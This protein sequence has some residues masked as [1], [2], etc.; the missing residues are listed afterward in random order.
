LT[1]VMRRFWIGSALWLAARAMAEPAAPSAE[2]IEPRAFGYTVGDVLQRR[3]LLQWQE[4]LAPDLSSL[5]QTRRPG[6]ALELRAARLDGHELRLEYQVFL[7][8]SEVRTLEMPPLQL[9]FAGPAGERFLRIDAWPVTV[10]PLVPVEVSPREGLGELRPDAPP[11]AI[12][13]AAR[14]LRLALYGGALALLLAYL[15]HVYVG[16]P[17]WGRR[18]R[19]FAMAWRAM[20]RLPAV[21]PPPQRRE[22]FRLIHQALNRSA[23]EV[24][25]EAG[26]PGF[27][28]RHPRFAPLRDDLAGF[29]RRS[30]DEFFAERKAVGVAS[31]IGWLRALCRACRDAER[32]IA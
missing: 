12:G 2:L 23:G 11:P 5:P 27:L 20:R 26:L 18:R 3:V 32:G 29:F 21:Q 22:A 31:D 13:T 17:W 8:P 14:Q 9:R 7:A 1:I 15:L 24:L 6:Q 10:A 4:G 25:F 16:L 30:S 19:P 28:A